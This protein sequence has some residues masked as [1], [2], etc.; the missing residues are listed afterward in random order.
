RPVNDGDKPIYTNGNWGI[1]DQ[2]KALQWVHKNIAN[3]GGDPD[4]V[5][6]AG[7]SAGA[8][9]VSSLIISPATDPERQSDGKPL[10]EH[11]IMESGNFLGY[12]AIS[13]EAKGCLDSGTSVGFSG[14]IQVCES[15]L[16]NKLNLSDKSADMGALRR[17]PS[18]E[19]ADLTK[20]NWE[21][22]M[23]PSGSTYCLL[24]SYDGWALPLDTKNWRDSPIKAVENGNFRNVDMLCGWN[25]GEGYGFFLNPEI[26]LHEITD[27]DIGSVT[28]KQIVQS[29]LINSKG[30]PINYE[31]YKS[32]FEIV[33]QPSSSN[34]RCVKE[35]R[36]L[37][38]YAAFASSSREFIDQV[39]LY[40]QNHPLLDPK[41]YFAY[42]F[43][44]MYPYPGY[45]SIKCEDGAAHTA[46]L[47]FVFGTEMEKAS[48]EDKRMSNTIMNYWTNFAKIGNVNDNGLLPWAEQVPDDTEVMLF[49]G[50]KADT[51]KSYYVGMKTLGD[52]DIK[53]LRC[54]EDF[55]QTSFGSPA[56][57]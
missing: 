23:L 51:T 49:S 22:T 3:F 45:P 41:N 6:I 2:I 39:I 34:F 44:Y 31:D 7:E 15:M 32:G 11:A 17:V 9:S 24:P 35:L 46:E 27:P 19:L 21:A 14:T 10:F 47:P 52:L 16:I 4:N 18:I 40:H 57:N 54:I 1:L 42:N 29:H 26:E 56:T 12:D 55:Y 8:F 13:N 38:K 37:D 50:G 30:D 36:D 20:V 43:D 33:P 53:K 28:F 25:T 48:P 5:T